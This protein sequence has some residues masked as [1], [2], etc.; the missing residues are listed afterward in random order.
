[1]WIEIFSKKFSRQSS[2]EFLFSFFFFKIFSSFLHSDIAINEQANTF[3]HLS[4]VD[5]SS[6]LPGKTKLGSD[7]EENSYVAQKR[8]KLT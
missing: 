8:P 5:T 2:D 4:C 3:S 6:V 7:E 1:M